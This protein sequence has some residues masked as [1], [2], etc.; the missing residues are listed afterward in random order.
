[1]PFAD[2]AATDDKNFTFHGA[3]TPT[4]GADCKPSEVYRENSFIVGLCFRRGLIAR[5]LDR[6]QNHLSAENRRRDWRRD[7]TALSQT[8]RLALGGGRRRASKRMPPN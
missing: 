2:A 5:R 4:D 1:M 7:F 3:I 6:V 8:A